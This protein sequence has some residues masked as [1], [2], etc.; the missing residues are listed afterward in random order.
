M[1]KTLLVMA[2]GT[3]GHVF[4][5]IAV[6]QW[7]KEQGGDVAWLGTEH[8]LDTKLV[9]PTGIPF[10]PIAIKGLRGKGLKSYMTAPWKIFR[11][12][13]QAMSVIR[14]INPDVVLSM[15]GYVAGPGGVAAKLLRKPLVVH[16]QNAIPGATNTILA[17]FA[18]K[19]L[20]AF[21][22]SFPKKTNA[23]WVGNPVRKDILSIASPEIRVSKQHEKLKLLIIGG[24]QG[25]QK[26]NSV[27]PKMLAIMDEKHRPSVWHQA[28]AKHFDDVVSF[29]KNENVDGKI[30]PFIDNMSEAFSWADLVICRSGALTVSEIAAV[31]IGSILIPFAQAVD[32]HRLGLPDAVDPVLRLQVHLRVLWRATK[33]QSPV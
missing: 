7:W 14:K 32:D 30:V 20:E 25:A 18:S 27:I 12:V 17:K 23:L 1:K 2:G 11:A 24:S 15:G 29:Y 10:Y 28:G 6:A 19:V 21:P 4:P 16:E 33:T 5:G 8:G 22:E 31:G 13:T 9:P 26:I 3:G